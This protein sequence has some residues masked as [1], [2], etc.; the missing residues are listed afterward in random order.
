[1]NE[2]LEYIRRRRELLV[3]R[4]DLQRFD[5]ELQVAPWKKS[6]RFV[7]HGVAL[8]RRAREHPTVLALALIVLAFIGRHRLRRVIGL[9]LSAWRVYR[10]FARAKKP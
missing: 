4:A 5:L 3:T 10:L 2:R 8:L 9:G 1:M 6:L 7:D